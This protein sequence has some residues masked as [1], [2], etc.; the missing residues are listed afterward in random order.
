MNH[1][2]IRAIAIGVTAGAGVFAALLALVEY[3]PWHVVAEQIARRQLSPAERDELERLRIEQQDRDRRNRAYIETEQQRRAERDAAV[4]AGF[5][6]DLLSTATVPV[7]DPHELTLADLVAEIEHA[8]QAYRH[9]DRGL[10]YPH[11]EALHLEFTRRNDWQA[12][13]SVSRADQ[14][15]LDLAANRVQAA[16]S[17]PLDYCP[18][19]PMVCDG[20]SDFTGP[21][22]ADLDPEN[23][24]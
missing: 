19:P 6:P 3:D 21:D 9:R 22:L 5:N 18:P 13:M 1:T 4:A 7:G 20:Y 23:G 15:R 8:E 10:L 16:R 12:R 24:W 11:R 2:T 14:L 17:Q